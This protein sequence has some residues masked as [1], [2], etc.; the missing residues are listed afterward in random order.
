MKRRL[1]LQ[2]T[3]SC[4]MMAGLLF[5]SMTKA[6]EG[7][8][9]WEKGFSV[10]ELELVGLHRPK[11]FGDGFN[12]RKQA[13]DAYD[14]MRAAALKKGIDLYSVSSYRSFDHQMGI[15][16]RKYKQ[17][18]KEGSSPE[19]AIQRIIEFSTLP[20]SSRHHW[21]T[22]LD[23]SDQAK[24]APEISPL[25]ASHFF[26]KDGIYHDLYQWMLA[27]AHEYGFYM[28]Y[29]NDPNRQ[30]FAYEPWH[31]SY[32]PLSIPLLIQ[33]KSV[34]LK[35]HIDHANLQGKSHLNKRFL[36]HY[37]KVWGFGINPCLIP[38]MS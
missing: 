35:K 25:I 10:P 2:K 4:V 27:H 30:G 28:P 24:P 19:K 3:S 16:N 34:S 36:E 9:S 15:W 32:A 11:L 23:I 37:K 38:N 6:A 13:A 17:Y 18:R 20:G 8:I 21:G 14:A 7:P 1:F 22:D 29:T 31:W 26:E 5:P 12:L 33:Y